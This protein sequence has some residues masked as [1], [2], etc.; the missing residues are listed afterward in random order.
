MAQH[1]L[2]CVPGTWEAVAAAERL[3]RIEPGSE[4]GMLTGVTDLLDHTVF[5]VVYVN[6]PASFGPIPGGGEGVLAALGRPSYRASRDMGIAELIRLIRA[7]EGS[8]G[9]LGY[10]Q[11][12]AV[13]SLVGRELVSGSLR[14]RA[15][16]CRWLHA[17]ASPH[18]APGRTFPLGNQL[19]GQGI[20]GDP[21]VDTGAIDWFDYCLPGDSYGDADPSNT[22]L[23][24][25]YELAIDLSLVDPFT[26]IAGIADSLLS[27]R[28]RDAI[29]E[30]GEDPLRMIHKVAVTAATVVTFL[31][32][33]PHD[34][35]GVREIVPGLTALRHSA[36]HLNFW[37]PRA[38][39]TEQL[40][41]PV[42]ALLYR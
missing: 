15:G 5:D 37:G 39:V 24:L 2:F 27:G 38:T 14:D 4:I 31:Q 17:F 19:V 10:S 32:G 30:L 42:T 28:L 20:S 33:F 22:Y 40:R 12:G 25:G 29:A 36:N 23:R 1:K 41:P 35:Y 18:R 26:M 34:K 3:G 8:F 11:G 21:V 6:Y 13:A 9:I 7:H 16:D